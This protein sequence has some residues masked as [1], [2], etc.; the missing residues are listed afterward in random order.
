MVSQC[1]K[2]HSEKL[3]FNEKHWTFLFHDP[4]VNRTSFF[5]NK[6]KLYFQAFYHDFYKLRKRPVIDLIFLLCVSAN[7]RSI[8]TNTSYVTLYK[9]DGDLEVSPN[10][11]CCLVGKKVSRVIWPA[12]RTK[13]TLNFL[14]LFLFSRLM[15]LLECEA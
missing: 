7:Q 9:E 10:V 11:T 2:S 14:T 8:I 5:Y 12:F 3:K 15:C 1:K 6:T 13:F 4:N